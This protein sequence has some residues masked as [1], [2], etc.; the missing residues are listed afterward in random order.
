MKWSYVCESE[1]KTEETNTILK[2]QVWSFL[3]L[4]SVVTVY[5]NVLASPCEE[6][7]I[8][9]DLSS[10]NI[11]STTVVVY[12]LQAKL[13]LRPG[14]MVLPQV[15]LLDSYLPGS[16][17]L[18][19]VDSSHKKLWNWT[20]AFI[21]KVK[22]SIL[23]LFY[24]FIISVVSLMRDLETRVQSLHFNTKSVFFTVKYGWNQQKTVCQFAWLKYS[25]YFGPWEGKSEVVFLTKPSSS[26]S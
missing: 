2:K 23:F 22:K 10:Q 7:L 17:A 20:A 8:Y 6:K 1:A 24:S 3:N 13:A 12:K 19:T 18:L 21:H 25:L 11:N 9:V 15:L 16:C 26:V 5:W 4:N 14:L